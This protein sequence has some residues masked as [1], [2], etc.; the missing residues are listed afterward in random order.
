MTI[1][2]RQ[3]FLRFALLLLGVAALVGAIAPLTAGAPHAVPGYCVG[4]NEPPVGSTRI[5]TP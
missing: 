5:C 4:G 1:T 2:V 3:Y